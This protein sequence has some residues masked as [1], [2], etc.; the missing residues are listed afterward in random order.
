MG[1]AGENER[2]SV[3]E[4]E[5]HAGVIAAVVVVIDIVVVLLYVVQAVQVRIGADAVR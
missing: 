5:V 1:D 4:L 3:G 2:L